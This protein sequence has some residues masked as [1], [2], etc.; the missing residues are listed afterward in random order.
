M[1]L[2]LQQQQ[3]VWS[4]RTRSDAYMQAIVHAVLTLAAEVWLCGMTRM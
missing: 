3:S 4:R 2:Q 1:Q